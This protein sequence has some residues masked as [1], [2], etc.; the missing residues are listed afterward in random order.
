MSKQVNHSGSNNSNNEFIPD[1][2][3]EI[4]YVP[5]TPTN[6]VHLRPDSDR[7]EYFDANV[8]SVG[9]ILQ[10]SSPSQYNSPVIPNNDSNYQQPKRSFSLKKII[11][12]SALLGVFSAVGLIAII[13][14][15]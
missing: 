15:Y 3:P 13:S 1:Q 9:D 6:P 14:L 11:L 12:L 2:L 7:V 10:S 5:V 8:Q 4:E